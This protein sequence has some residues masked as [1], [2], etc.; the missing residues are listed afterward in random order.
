M[1]VRPET[2]RDYTAI[3]DLHVRAFGR[4]EEALIVTLLR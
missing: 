2:P 4:T 1:N 3:A